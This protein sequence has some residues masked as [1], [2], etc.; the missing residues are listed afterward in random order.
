MSWKAQYASRRVDAATA[1]RMVPS[2]GT[3]YVSGNAA[4]PLTLVRALA[5]RTDIDRPIRVMHMLFLGDDPFAGRTDAFLHHTFFA[6]RADRDLIHRGLADYVPVHLHRI[7]EAIRAGPELDAAFLG[8]G[9]PDAHG[10]MSLGVEVLSSWAA[11]ARARSVVVQVNEAMPRV[12]GDTFLHVSQVAAVVEA[13]EPLPELRPPTPTEVHRAIARRV[14]PLVPDGATLQLGI[15]GVPDAVLA[16]LTDPAS[17]FARCDLGLHS[18]MV[19]DG[20]LP[21]VRS[22]FVTGKRKRVHPGKIVI[23]FA[24]GTKALYDYLHDNP[25]VQALPCNYVNDPSVI[26]RNDRVVAINSALQVDLTGQVAAESMGPRIWSG[27][28]GQLDFLRGA[29]ASKDGVPVIALPSTAKGG[30]VSRIVARLDP[31]AGV[32]TTRADV[33]HVVTEHAAVNLFAKPL[34]ERAELLIAAAA[35]EFRDELREAARE[36]GILRRS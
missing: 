8:V 1:A 26:A 3:V 27:F 12:H 14:A 34:T 16:L 20:L 18:E 28:G 35:P 19:S 7:P 29:A 32:L 9:P 2:G 10:W 22:G 13:T 6:G 25:A 30:T 4:T 31:G 15:G 36:G 17:G 11:I 33:H 23:T 5:Q 21:A 24:M